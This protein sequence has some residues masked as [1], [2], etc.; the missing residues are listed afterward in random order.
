MSKNLKRSEISKSDKEIDENA[1]NMKKSKESK[2]G[3]PKS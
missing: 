1:R 2:K 3:A